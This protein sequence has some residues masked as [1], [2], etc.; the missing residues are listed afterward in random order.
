M[1]MLEFMDAFCSLTPEQ[2]TALEEFTYALCDENL[3]ID[4]ALDKVSNERLR[5]SYRKTLNRKLKG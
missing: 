4:Q 1:E 3:S 5:E 2:M